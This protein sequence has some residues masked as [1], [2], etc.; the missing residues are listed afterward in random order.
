[1]DHATDKIFFLYF[2]KY[3]AYE[4]MFQVKVVDINDLSEC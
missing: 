4:K 1:M 3:I 2:I